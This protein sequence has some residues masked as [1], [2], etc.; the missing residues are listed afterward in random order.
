L[1]SSVLDDAKLAVNRRGR[2]ERCVCLLLLWEKNALWEKNQIVTEKTIHPRTR[3]ERERERE[4]KM[5]QAAKKIDSAA[6]Q[7]FSGES[8]RGDENERGD[9]VAR[10]RRE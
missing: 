3:K 7:S 8:S 2:S 6:G 4:R 5:S 1:L 9:F 10:N